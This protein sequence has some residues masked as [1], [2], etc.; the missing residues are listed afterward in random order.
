MHRSTRTLGVLWCIVLIAV[1][2]TAG[3]GLA[4]AAPE[5]AANH[6]LPPGVS[7]DGVENASALVDGHRDSLSEVGGTYVLTAAYGTANGSLSI[8]QSTVGLVAPGLSPFRVRT[9]GEYAFGN[10]SATYTVDQWANDTVLLTRNA[11]NET[12]RFDKQFLATTPR[13]DDPFNDSIP[14]RFVEEHAIGTNFLRA[15]LHLGNFSVVSSPGANLTVLRATE[16]NESIREDGLNATDF[17]ATLTVTEDGLVRSFNTSVAFGLG[18]EQFDY[19]FGFE[20]LATGGEPIEPAWTDRAM[21]RTVATL[22]MD[23]NDSHF[24]LTNRGPDPLPPGTTVSVTHRRITAN[25]TLTEPLGV[26]ETAY[27]YY[28]AGGGPP[29]LALDP[30][31]RNATVDLVGTYE[32]VVRDPTGEAMLF[33]SFGFGSNETS[34][35]PESTVRVRRR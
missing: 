19:A 11:D 23:S 7:A 12:V 29:Q 18:D 26:G 27:I 3:T 4:A 32:F 17:D 10:E 21:N 30:P 13:P 24:T 34:P 25:V 22:D 9:T 28:P 15:T 6:G 16:L 33:A 31:A 35:P 5:T 20:L 14:R 8:G 2:A 1:S